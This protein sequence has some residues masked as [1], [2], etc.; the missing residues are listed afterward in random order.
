[1]QITVFGANGKVGNLIVS[2]ALQNGIKVKAFVHGKSQLGVSKDLNVISGDIYNINDVE[3]AISGSDAVISALGSWGTPKKD[4]LTMGMKNIIP[5]MQKYGVK[6]IVSLTGTDASV[7]GESYD[8]FGKFIKAL[9]KLFAN[10]ILQDGE[11][12]IQLLIDSE[13]EWTVVRSPVMNEVG[14]KSK[15]VLTKS[16]PMLWETINRKSVA[17]SMVE[18]IRSDDFIKQ[19]P[20][21]RRK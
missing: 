18:L 11:H 6:R 14:L 16:K 13:L 2:N 20:F 9:L 21:I 17:I 4:I 5:C 19:A 7:K 12:H 3:N 8:I 10:K 1:M 15:F